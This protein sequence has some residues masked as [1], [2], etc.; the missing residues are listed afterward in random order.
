CVS[1]ATSA[2]VLVGAAVL[3]A[4]GCGSGEKPIDVSGKVTFK[5]EPVTEGS[6]Q[7]IEDRTGRGAQVDLGPDGTYT[8]SLFAGEYKVVVTP[9]YIE[10]MS[11]GMPNPYYKKVKNIPKK[12]HSTDTSG[13]SATV[14]RDKTT[15]DF[16][17]SP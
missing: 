1:R 14:S 6:I 10:D 16:A 17:L 12:Y 8:A 3:L 11:S 9:P 13:L 5:G 2:V 7:F 4:A 15:H